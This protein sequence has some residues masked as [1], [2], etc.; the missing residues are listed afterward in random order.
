MIMWSLIVGAALSLVYGLAYDIFGRKL[1][2]T[3][4]NIVDSLSATANLLMGEGNEKTPMLLLRDLNF[5]K[6]TT[7]STYRK[8]IIPRGTDVYAPLLKVYK[9]RK[10]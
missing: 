6:F 7:K 1:K 4:A 10:K 8:I 2:V 9:T 5:V 3:R